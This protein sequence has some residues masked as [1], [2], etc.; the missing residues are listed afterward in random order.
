MSVHFFE[1]ENAAR[2][3]QAGQ[4]YTVELGDTTY[5]SLQMDAY[6]PGKD[7][8]SLTVDLLSKS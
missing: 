7:D 8:P 2:S 1:S 4:T 6:L 3:W 5:L